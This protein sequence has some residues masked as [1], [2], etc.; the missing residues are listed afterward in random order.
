M[1]TDPLDKALH[2][3]KP[4]SVC[5]HVIESSIVTPNLAFT[6]INSIPHPH[7]RARL[8]RS[9]PPQTCRSSSPALA[10]GASRILAAP[11]EPTSE[12][13]PAIPFRDS[14]QHTDH[15]NPPPIESGVDFGS[16]P[17]IYDEYLLS[18]SS[19]LPAVLLFV[20][21]AGGL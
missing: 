18:T 13:I 6:H 1:A 17:Y 3:L 20:A 19:D 10:T 5:P 11:P 15:S 2:P 14:Q 12:I 8:S 9:P 16:L 21:W 4:L 7:P